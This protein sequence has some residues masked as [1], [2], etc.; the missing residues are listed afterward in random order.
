MRTIF[1]CT[2]AIAAAG[3]VLATTPTIDGLNIATEFAN[4]A[5]AVQ[6]TNTQFGD[7][8]N[9]LNRM[10]VTSDLNNM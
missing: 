9:E 3:T 8:E 7:N 5:I 2:F 10:F 4:P 6:D 1:K